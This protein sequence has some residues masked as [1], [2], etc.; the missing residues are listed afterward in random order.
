MQ[1]STAR[2]ED[3]DDQTQNPSQGRKNKV[4]FAAMR[5]QKADKYKKNSETSVIDTR[6]YHCTQQKT[7]P[8]EIVKKKL[9]TF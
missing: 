5:E 7:A 2:R 6:N 3:G 9:V 4:A 1:N 8:L